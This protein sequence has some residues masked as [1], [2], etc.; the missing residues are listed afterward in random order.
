[1]ITTNTLILTEDTRD[2]SG[3][4]FCAWISALASGAV[5]ADQISRFIVP[6]FIPVIL[7]TATIFGVFALWSILS[8]M[9][10]RRYVREADRRAAMLALGAILASLLPAAWLFLGLWHVTAGTALLAFVNTAAFTA[11]AQA[12][13]IT[14]RPRA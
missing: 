10:A 12:A 7:G 2:L 14:G 4:A 13:G 3:A 8:T 5:A 11:L 6:A 1:M 9:R